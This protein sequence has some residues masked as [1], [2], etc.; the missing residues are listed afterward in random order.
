MEMEIAAAGFVIGMLIVGIIN[1]PKIVRRIG[2]GQGYR[3]N[4]KKTK[5]RV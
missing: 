3:F 1:V 5:R 4:I 2:G